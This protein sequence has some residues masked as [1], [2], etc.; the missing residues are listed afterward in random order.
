MR[1]LKL[2]IQ[3]DEMDESPLEYSDWKHVSFNNKHRGFCDPYEYLQPPNEHGEVRGVFGFHNKLKHGTA[4]ILSCYEHSGIAWSLM[5]EGTQ[6]EFDSARV[7]G[8][9]IYEGDLKWLPK[10]YKERQDQ[11]RSMVDVFTN[12]CN[13]QVFYYDL[14]EIT[15]CSKCG[16]D[17]HVEEIDSCGGYYELHQVVA[18]AALNIVEGDEITIAGQLKDAVDVDDLWKAYEEIKALHDEE[19]KDKLFVRL[20][21]VG[22]P[23]FDQDPDRPKYGCPR[24]FQTE[25]ESF[26]EATVQCRDYI[27]KH[28]LGGGN[29]SGGQ[30]TK[31]GEVIARV[32]YNGRVW[33][34]EG[35]PIELEKV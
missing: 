18:N 14:E 2:T 35:N 31:N 25:V 23:D 15:P 20:A 5:G 6:C 3:Y 4:F 32:S 1:K 12:Y 19:N 21:N 30:I 27:T 13:G 7:A 17:D 11:A 24:E 16:N 26:E 33:D 34:L 8:L 9:L 29:W 10:T 22:N 28:N